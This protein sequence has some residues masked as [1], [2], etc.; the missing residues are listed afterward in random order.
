MEKE[1]EQ[2]FETEGKRLPEIRERFAAQAVRWVFSEAEIWTYADGLLRD[3]DRDIVSSTVSASY[4]CGLDASEKPVLLKYFDPEIQVDASDPASLV[5]EE[6]PLRH[7]WAEEFIT[8]KGDI[9][10]VS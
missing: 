9:L 8:H 1:I 4:A 3:F 7:T 2:R 6:F 10:E 5:N